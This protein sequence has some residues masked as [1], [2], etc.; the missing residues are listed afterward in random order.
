[1]ISV[2]LY[3]IFYFV[4]SI[5]TYNVLLTQTV[6]C[7]LIAQDMHFDVGLLSYVFQ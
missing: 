1:M 2:Y 5:Q 4:F 3:V 6:L 7:L